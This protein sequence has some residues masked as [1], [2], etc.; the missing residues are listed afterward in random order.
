MRPAGVPGPV[1]TSN[2][3]KLIIEDVLGVGSDCVRQTMQINPN[4]IPLKSS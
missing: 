3:N 4:W 2:G 1:R